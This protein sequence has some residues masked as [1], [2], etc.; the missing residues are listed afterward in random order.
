MGY[1]QWANTLNKSPLST[2]WWRCPYRG[3]QELRCW[4]HIFIVIS[5]VCICIRSKHTSSLAKI[6]TQLE[7]SLRILSTHIS[8]FQCS[9]PWL[10]RYQ[11]I[12]L[13]YQQPILTRWSSRQAFISTC[14]YIQLTHI[15]L[16]NPLSLS[17]IIWFCQIELCISIIFGLENI[18]LE[19]AWFIDFPSFV[20]FVLLPYAF[21]INI[22]YYYSYH[23]CLV[24]LLILFYF[25]TLW[26]KFDC[27]CGLCFKY[28]CCQHG[29]TLTFPKKQDISASPLELWCIGFE[30]VCQTALWYSLH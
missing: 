23:C 6:H 25:S 12:T 9:L 7:V 21:H 2:M 18:Q 26:K 3:H 30:V 5:Y 24:G 1:S 17:F 19:I 22:F 28:L 8:A 13:N 15:L 20:F 14:P 11:L 27:S 29:S 16:S 4:V 10:Q